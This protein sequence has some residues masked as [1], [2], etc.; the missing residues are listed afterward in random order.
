MTMASSLAQCRGCERG[1]ELV[2]LGPARLD[3]L[4]ELTGVRSR[5]SGLVQTGHQP[6]AD[7]GGPTR[8][9]G[10][11][12]MGGR[13]RAFTRRIDRLLGASDHEVVDAVLHVPRSIGRAEDTLLVGLVVRHQEVWVAV[14]GQ[15]VRA[16]FGVLG[17]QE[18]DTAP[19]PAA[20]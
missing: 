3:D 18:A 14:A 17:L 1:I 2:R 4:V 16:Q 9:D 11:L 5:R 7:G 20:P 8:R 13:L 6:Q 12:I 15:V 10:D 19:P